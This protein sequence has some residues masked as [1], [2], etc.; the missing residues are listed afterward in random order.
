MDSWK[1]IS[2]IA[3]GFGIA[4]VVFS[5]FQFLTSYESYVLGSS[6]PIRFIQV[7]AIGSMLTFLL[8][9]VLSFIVWRVIMPSQKEKLQQK[10]NQKKCTKNGLNHKKK[11]N[12]RRLNKKKQKQKKTNHNSFLA[13]FKTKRLNS[14]SYPQKSNL[15]IIYA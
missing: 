7:N 12:Q 1:I 5:I 2:K 10:R 11:L 13:F 3:F 9:G 8:L 4:F 14:E 15:L 6:A